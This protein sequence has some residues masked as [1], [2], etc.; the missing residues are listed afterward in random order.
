MGL[1][2]L[3]NFWVDSCYPNVCNM[4]QLFTCGCTC[5]APALMLAHALALQD[6]EHCFSPKRR[7]KSSCP[8]HWRRLPLFLL[9]AKG[10]TFGPWF[11]QFKRVVCYTKLCETTLL[12][13]VHP[14][15]KQQNLMITPSTK[16]SWCIYIYSNIIC[17]YIYIDIILVWR[18]TTTHTMCAIRCQGYDQS[19][20][21]SQV[22]AWVGQF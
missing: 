2:R 18:G 1:N 6:F 17:M 14:L 21:S 16:H 9:S 10:S 11:E 15:P 8:R 22:G 7:T 20:V 12:K 4:L 13:V 3:C 19:F 5:P